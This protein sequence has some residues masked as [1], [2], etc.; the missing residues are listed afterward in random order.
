MLQQATGDHPVDRLRILAVD[1][2]ELGCIDS[3]G[4]SFLAWWAQAARTDGRPAPIRRATPRFGRVLELSGLA[5][6]FE[7]VRTPHRG[8]VAT[9]RRS[10]RSLARL[11]DVLADDRS[12]W[13][14]NGQTPPV[15]STTGGH[16]G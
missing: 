4:V 12:A 15:A 6:L 13:P 16:G 2:G 8:R 14:S 10:I 5:P 3:T 9:G 1:V 7:P 11:A